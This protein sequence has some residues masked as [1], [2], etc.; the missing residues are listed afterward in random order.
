MSLFES[1]YNIKIPFHDLDPMNVVWHGNYI[2]YLEQA[3]CDMFDKLD[4][5]YYDMKDDNYVY[6]VA[7]LNTKYIKP[8]SFNQEVTIKASLIEIEPAIII[9]YKM[10]NKTDIVFEAETMQIGINITTGE[11]VYNAPVKL[12]KVLGIHNEK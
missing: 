5:T 6:P 4:Y 10:F 3:R 7:K 9:K 11:S 12:L 2:K 8:L 1:E